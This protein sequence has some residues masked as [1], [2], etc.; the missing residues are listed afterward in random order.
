MG[1]FNAF[2]RT[3]LDSLRGRTPITC[4]MLAYSTLRGKGDWLVL[5]TCPRND[6]KLCACSI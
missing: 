3:Y 5:P 6:L 4:A 1:I 2:A